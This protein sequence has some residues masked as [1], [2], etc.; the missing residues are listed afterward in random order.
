MLSDTKPE[1]KSSSVFPHDFM[2]GK[3]LKRGSLIEGVLVSITKEG[4]WVD[5]NAKTEGIVPVAEMKT[6]QSANG[7]KTG[8]KVLVFVLET[9]NE[10]GR[11]VL[12][13]DRAKMIKG[14]Q[15]IEKGLSDG[16]ALEVEIKAFNKGGLL[17]DYQNIQGF[18]PL[19]HVFG[20]RRFDDE[21]RDSFLKS[22][23]GQKIKIKVL[24]LDRAKHRLIFSEKVVMQESQEKVREQLL[25]ELKEGEVKKGKITSVHEF[26]AFV[27]IGGV[28]GLLPISEVGWDRDIKVENVLK[29]DCELEVY[30]LKVDKEAKKV[31]LSQKR[32]LPH[33]WTLAGNKYQAGQIVS[34]EITR[35]KPFGAFVALDEFIEGLIHISEISEKRISHPKEQLKRGD[36]V[37]V[38][39]LAVD[40]EKRR[41]SLS[42]KQ[43]QQEVV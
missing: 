3:I 42:L 43:V 32:L 7:L 5:V 26:G 17:V 20:L 25:A 14:W 23:V 16:I 1:V 6:F 28:D 19:S 27:D 2:E 18:V 15:D 21:G 39:V 31:L 33:P 22:K 9:E 24:E 37:T 35:L 34:G 30:V 4:L 8:D 40:P 29:V 13:L 36:T 11:A 41:I 12:S 10:D 38:K